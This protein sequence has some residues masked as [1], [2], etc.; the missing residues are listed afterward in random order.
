MYRDYAHTV[1]AA[2]TIAAGL[3]RPDIARLHW[4][5][6]FNPCMSCVIICRLCACGRC[7]IL[8]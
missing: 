3:S 7:G 8:F 5:D 2:F 6:T 1:Y 4:V